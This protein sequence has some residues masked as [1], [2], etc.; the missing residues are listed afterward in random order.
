MRTDGTFGISMTY[1]LGSK[2]VSPPDVWRSKMEL[3]KRPPLHLCLSHRFASTLARQ[4]HSFHFA[5]I[6]FKGR[7][8]GASSISWINRKSVWTI[9]EIAGDEFVLATQS[10][11]KLHK[12]TF[13]TD[14]WRNCCSFS[15]RKFIH[16]SVER[17]ETLQVWLPFL[18]LIAQPVSSMISR[19]RKK[20]KRFTM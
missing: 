16:P 7:C 15:N 3:Q 6:Q 5:R 1:F 19:K 8:R 2:R 12:I 20:E 10:H 9:L 11:P 18:E 14:Y 13:S 17:T 4:L